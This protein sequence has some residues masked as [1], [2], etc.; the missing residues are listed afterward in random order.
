M[1]TR[2]TCGLMVT[3]V[4]CC[5][6]ACSYTW[7]ASLDGD[8]TR[9]TVQL[10][11]VENRLFPHRPGLEYELT[12]RLKEEIALDR[13]LILGE[14]GGDVRLKVSLTTF[15]EPNL[16]EDFETG[17]PAEI[18]LRATATVEAS[19]EAFTGG[20]VRRKVSVSTSYTPLLGDSKREGLDR[21]WRDLAREILDIAADKEWA[22]N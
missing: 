10:D 19:G 18:L 2:L 17:Q 5:M 22:A 13:R 11:T 3:A 1:A 6:C 15:S 12:D 7:T 16:V 21:L 8:G 20:T 4:L 9:R 14:G